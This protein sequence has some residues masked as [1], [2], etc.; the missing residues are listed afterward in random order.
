M[1]SGNTK[2]MVEK[3]G[4]SSQEELTAAVA[5]LSP[6]LKAKLMEAMTPTTFYMV[7]HTFVEGK[8]EGYMKM[9]S[10]LTAEDSMAMVKKNKELGFYSHFALPH[11][12][13]SMHCLW[14]AKGEVSPELFQKYIDGPDGLGEGV[15][16]NKSH[17]II[18]GPMLPPSAFTTS[19]PPA[20][21]SPGCFFVVIHEFKEGTFSGFMSMLS[22]MSKEEWATGVT[23]MKELGFYNHAS[24]STGMTEK[25]DMFCVFESKTDMSVEDFRKFLDGPDGPG[26]GA[27][28]NFTV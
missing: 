6:E 22:G 17:K 2:A 18:P 8:A 23:K 3:L 24:C 27:V 7:K 21:K 5:S 25:D 15:F 10:G 26:A 13:G 28:F 12:D 14:E 19:V 1:G 9:L 11:D 20:V 4:E 16:V